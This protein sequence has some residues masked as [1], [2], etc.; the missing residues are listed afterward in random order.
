MEHEMSEPASLSQSTIA[1]TA[2]RMHGVGALA[3]TLYP[4]TTFEVGSVEESRAL[5]TQ[6]RPTHF[7]GRYGNPT[8]AEFEDAIA[9]LEGAEAARAFSSGMAAISATILG[10]CSKGSHIVASRQLYGGTRQL[11]EQVCPRFGIDV[12]FV[13][14][15]RPGAMAEAVVVGRT[16]LVVAET[17]ANPRL[18]LVDLDELGAISGPFTVVDS[19]F[20]TPLGQSPIAHG[21][22]LVIHS[23]SKAIG[24]HNDAI[25]G[26]VAG[27][28]DLIDW[29][30]GFSHL[31][32]GCASPVDALNGLRG[33]RTLPVRFAQQCATA[34]SVATFLESHP[35]VSGVRYPGL[36]SHPRYDLARRQLRMDG[37]LLTFDLTAGGEAACAFVDRLRLILHA[38]SLG[39]PETLVCHPASTTHVGLDP[40]DL[41]ADGI[42][43]GTIR[44]SCGLEDTADVVADLAQALGSDGTV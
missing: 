31:H 35:A 13:D 24:G 5:A 15:T 25:L 10:L 39:G 9:K 3:P 27:S 16:T 43:P 28:A 7:Y 42:G 22:D 4:T 26:V 19:T 33:L 40:D 34:A 29:I 6:I 1:I 44:L 14:G 20:A 23:A 21:V 8:V 30:T 38:P 37:G 12:T 2:G 11:L 36:A 18:D 32:G 41:A 17:P